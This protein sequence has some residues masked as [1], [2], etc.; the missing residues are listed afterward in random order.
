M[1]EDQGDQSYATETVNITLY[2]EP[3][4]RPQTVFVTEAFNTAVIDTACTKTVC[5]SK[6]LRQFVESL[7]NDSRENELY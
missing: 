5:G 6:W 3:E 1:T 4:L 7:D 2:I